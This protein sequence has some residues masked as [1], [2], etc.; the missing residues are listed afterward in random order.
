M[1]HA[2]NTFFEFYKCAVGG[3]VANDAFD[4]AAD[5]VFVVDFIPWVGFELACAEGEF[6]VFFADADDHG[7]DFLA[8]GENI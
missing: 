6:L 1:D 8:D 2:V 4:V 7:F 3:E 5:G